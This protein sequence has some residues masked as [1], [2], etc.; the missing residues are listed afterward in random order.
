MDRASTG[1]CAHA[2][3]LFRL[4]ARYFL[5]LRQKKVSKEKATPTGP[6]ALRLPCDARRSGPARNSL[7]A[8]AQTTAPDDSRPVCASR[9]PQRGPRTTQRQDFEFP[10]GQFTAQS[11]MRA[12]F[13]VFPFGP[14]DKRRTLRG[15]RRALSEGAQ[16]PSCAA[17]EESEHRRVVMRS[18][19]GPVGVAFFWLLFLAKQEK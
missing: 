12:S 3:T 10:T 11:Q 8:F 1:T 17:A 14:A 18:M 2:G 19:T 5:L 13:W 15:S 9:R 6:V 16:R 4:L 7:T